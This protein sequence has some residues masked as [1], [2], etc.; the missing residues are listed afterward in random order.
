MPKSGADEPSELL[1]PEK[2]I[3][4]VVSIPVGVY[5]DPKSPLFPWSYLFST[6]LD[7]VM[8]E[9]MVIPEGLLG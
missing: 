8:K 4:F 2:I 9:G 7:S 3:L 5:L 6:V 1:K